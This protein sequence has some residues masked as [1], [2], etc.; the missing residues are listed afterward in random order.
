MPVSKPQDIRNVALLGHGGAGKTTLAEA[1]LHAAKVT[2]RLGTVDD[3][4]THLD[5]TDIEKERKHSVDPAV[6]FLDHAG[7]TLNIVD[8]PGYPD[9]IGGA[10]SAASGSDIAVIVISA[11]AGIEVNTRRMFKLAKEAGMP[12]AMVINK[13]DAENVDLPRLMEA[14]TETFGGQCK[15]M[16]LPAGGGKQIIDCFVNDKGSSDLGDVADFRTQLM[17]DIIE[18][19]EQLMEAYLGGEQIPPEKLAAALVTAMVQHAV[20]PILFTAAKAEIGVTAFMDAVANFFPSPAEVKGLP[21]RS[22]PEAD[23]PEVPFTADAAKPLIAHTFKITTDPFVGKLAWIRVL[24]GTMTP[25]SVY[26]LRDDKK[27]AKVSHLYKLQ[28]KSTVDIPKAVAG[29]LIALAKVED[30]GTGDVLH[31]DVA[32]MYR[33]L[34][35]SPTPMY[36]LAV[37][38]KSRGDEQKISGSLHKLAEEDHTFVYH[39]D[40]QTNEMVISGIGDLHLRIMLSKMKQRFDL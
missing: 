35:P 18:V 19:D 26:H 1:M 2:G 11:S 10:I 29:D 9:F 12:I 32:P 34:M 28:G 38:P 16:N 14:I 4:T 36:S 6:A 13:I 37:T 7:K 39:R 23:A 22:G 31:A 3:G 17:E 33:G 25:E 30:I 27:T 24:Q 5:F 15:P 8:A 21:V 40:N 20:M